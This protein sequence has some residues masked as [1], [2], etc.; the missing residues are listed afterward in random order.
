VSKPLKPYDS[1]RAFPSIW[2]SRIPAHWE[3][4]RLGALLRERG[5]VNRDLRIVQVLSL[6]RDIGVI[7]YEEKGNIGNKKSEDIARYKIVREND[8]VLNSM[9]VIIGSVGR[10]RYEGCLS[11]VYYVL[12]PR[13]STFSPHFVERLFQVKSFQQSLIRIGYGILNHRMRIPMELLKSESLPVPSEEEQE[14][15]V[16]FIRH[17]DHRVNRLIKAKRKLIELLNEQKQA[18]I[19][20]AVTRGLDPSV[21]LKPSGIPWIGDIPQHWDTLLFGRL[22]TRVEQGWS[23]VAA[24]GELALDQWAVLTLSAV[25]RGTFNR[26]AIKPVSLTANIP[27]GIEVCDGDVL[28]TRSNTRDRVGDVC[29]VRTPRAKTIL[30][31]LIYRL[32]V[33]A[34]AIAP[35][36]LV[37]QLLSRVG[38]G[39]IERDARGSSGTMP[40]ISQ[41]HIKSWRIL[42]PPRDEQQRIVEGIDADS[43]PMD[44]A[45]SRLEREIELLR[46]YR[47]RLVADVV[48]GQLDA[49]HLNLPDVI[50]EPVSLS[51]ELDDCDDV[52]DDDLVEAEV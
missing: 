6:L 50:D 10:S 7:P 43:A 40:K 49:R 8:L 24:E 20:R 18:I 5:E 29:I 11:P 14:A 25:R 37:Y 1:Y 42:L 17:L 38:R 9:N 13:D 35:E 30:C 21:S 19:H 45:I 51:D 28:L 34:G 12:T 2:C 31:D 44:I 47:T 23:P 26:F 41:R 32:Q 16:R 52:P 36:F 4:K 27:T 48:T 33:R 15:I 22:L 39:Q 46:E 3:I